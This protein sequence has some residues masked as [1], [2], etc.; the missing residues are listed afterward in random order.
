[1][2]DYR[3]FSISTL[4]LAVALHMGLSFYHASA[5]PQAER[6]ASHISR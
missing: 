1:M 4:L 6:V 2:T 3:V 5:A